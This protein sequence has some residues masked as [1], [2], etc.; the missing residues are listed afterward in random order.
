LGGCISIE[1]PFDI[2]PAAAAAAAGACGRKYAVGAGDAA[3]EVEQEEAAQVKGCVD[4]GVKQNSAR[5]AV[6]IS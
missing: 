5:A 2:A 6:S 4:V 1:F 3:E